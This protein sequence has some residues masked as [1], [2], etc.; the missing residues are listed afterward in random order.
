MAVESIPDT[1]GT[2]EIWSTLVVSA[3]TVRTVVTVTETYTLVL[4]VLPSKSVYIS[5]LKQPT[6]RLVVDPGKIIV[7]GVG[8][9]MGG[10]T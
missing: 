2:F 7:V 6:S 5:E 9:V 8:K 1:M 10:K 3:G 4:L